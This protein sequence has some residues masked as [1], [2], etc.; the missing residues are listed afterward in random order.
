M[1]AFLLIV[2]AMIAFLFSTGCASTRRASETPAF[3]TTV[4]EVDL[5]ALPIF[6]G[7]TG[8]RRTLT[9]A[10][11]VFDEISTDAGS[12]GVAGGVE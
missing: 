6:D 11:T 2:I 12:G 4:A 3:Q 5:G 1:P 7:P 10:L 8:L 9:D